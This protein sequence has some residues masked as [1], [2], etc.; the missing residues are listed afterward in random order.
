MAV[1]EIV[2]SRSVDS[3]GYDLYY[4]NINSV[5]TLPDAQVMRLEVNTPTK[6][7]FN[8]SGFQFEYTDYDTF[9]V[10]GMIQGEDYRLKVTTSAPIDTTQLYMSMYDPSHLPAPFN[11]DRNPADGAYYSDVFTMFSTWSTDIHLAL[12]G[13]STSISNPGNVVYYVELIGIGLEPPALFTDGDDVVSLTMPGTYDALDGND[14]VTGTS[15]SDVISGGKGNDA[16][17]GAGGKDKLKGNAGAD[18][19]KGQNGNDKLDGGRGD[20]VILGGNGNDRIIGGKG[21]DTLTGGADADDFI[22]TSTRDGSDRITDFEAGVDDIDLRKLD[23]GFSDL[24]IKKIGGGDNT[25][26]V[27]DDLKIVLEDVHKSEI[28]AGDFIF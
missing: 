6:A 14:T 8:F 18:T 19:L 5:L 27:Y 17:K 3:S 10:D 26:I 20:D 12:S 9:A 21:N 22:Y 23:I 15:E 1:T 7:F 13:Y 4:S 25:K 24:T 16:L 28:D 11:L 2:E